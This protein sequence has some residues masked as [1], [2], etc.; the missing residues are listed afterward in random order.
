[1]IVWSSLNEFK[2]SDA[3]LH[4][5][6]REDINAL[7]LGSGRPFILEIKEPAI[8]NINLLELQKKINEENNGKIEVSR[9]SYTSKEAIKK[10]KTVKADKVY[11]IKIVLDGAIETE[12]LN[13]ALAN[14]EGIIK[15]KTPS[16]VLHRRADLQRKRKVREARLISLDGK[17][18]E[19]EIICEGGLYIKELIFGDEGRTEPNLSC[20]LD[21]D[22][23]VDK[24]DVIDVKIDESIIKSL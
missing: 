3:F 7:M 4:G 14:L 11:R 18:A 24:L 17:T 12:R 16:R 23:K 10:I 19:I 1:M 22:I 6:G 8:R 2:G 15:Q 13:M 21:M 9:L 5:A 20:L